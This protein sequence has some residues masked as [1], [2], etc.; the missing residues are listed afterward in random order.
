[1]MRQEL[2]RTRY[3][4]ALRDATARYA[5]K[6]TAASGTAPMRRRRLGRLFGRPAPA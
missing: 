4:Q 3:A 2:A 1:M 5:P 6:Q